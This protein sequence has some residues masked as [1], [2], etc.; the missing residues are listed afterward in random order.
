MDLLREVRFDKMP[1]STRCLQW[2]STFPIDMHDSGTTC[3]SRM[4]EI[5]LSDA[6]R[7]PGSRQ[8]T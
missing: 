7:T 4:N 1:K 6:T 5:A 8:A 3:W 2:K